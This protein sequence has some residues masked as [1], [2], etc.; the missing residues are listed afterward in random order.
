MGKNFITAHACKWHAS[1]LI[2]QIG[3][4]KI[5]LQIVCVWCT[6]TH[7]HKINMRESACGDI[8]I[9]QNLVQKN[10]RKAILEKKKKHK[11]KQKQKPTNDQYII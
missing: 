6:N 2:V 7:T 5:N 4:K 1:V 11:Q 9:V 10:R 3:D 8:E